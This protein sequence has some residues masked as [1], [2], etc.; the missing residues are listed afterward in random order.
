[1]T[2]EPN[3]APKPVS[4][5]DALAIGTDGQRLDRIA[6]GELSRYLQTTLGTREHWPAALRYALWAI[7][8]PR[9]GASRT[10]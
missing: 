2:I 6:V 8:R 10:A 7:E 3:A 5:F 1:M 4:I 9:L